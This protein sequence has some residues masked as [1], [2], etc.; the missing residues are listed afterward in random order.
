M[1]EASLRGAAATIGWDAHKMMIFSRFRRVV[2]RRL[3]LAAMA[4]VFLSGLTG[5]VGGSAPASA[6]SRPGLPVEYLDVPSASMGRDIRVQ[7]QGG[8]PKAIY[9][10][11]GLRAQE[12]FNGWDINTEAFEWYEQSGVSLVMP[13]GGQSSWYTDWYKPAKGK[14]GVW[15]YKWET[16]ITSELPQWLAA[17]RGISPTGNAVVGLSMGGAPAFT[18]AIYHPQQFIYA[19]ALSAFLNPSDMK[20]RVGLAMGD[21]GGFDKN[22]MWGPDDDPAWTRNDPYVNVGKLVAADTRLWIYCGSG[23]AT[24]LDKG[25][26][27]IEN[28]NG[29]VIEGVAI[30][31]NKN[32]IKAY[33]AAGG[34]NAYVN[35]PKGGLHNWTYWGQQLLA[36]KPDVV[37]YLQRA[38]IG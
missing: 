34:T 5:V 8:G 38:N 29:G 3:V 25:R 37:G 1:G 20:F 22:D 18:L 6:F 36:M 21:A 2:A 12:D 11:D 10:L 26:N 4:A 24:D 35:F 14:D 33:T 16:F 13:V 31:E 30:G 7:F 32:F 27:G 17:N 23:D 15:T 28:F 19:S 9:L